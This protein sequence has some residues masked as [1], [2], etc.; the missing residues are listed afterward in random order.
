MI[1]IALNPGFALV[2]GAGLALA[3]PQAI[4]TTLMALSGIAACALILAPPF[5]D[6]DRFAQIGLQLVPL[7]L[8]ALSQIFGLSFAIGAI[9]ISF[10]ASYRRRRMEDVAIML[11]AGGATSAAFAGDLISFVAASEVS[12]LAG[13]WIVFSAGGRAALESGVRLLI[14]QGL[15]GLLLFSGIALHLADGFNSAFTRLPADSVGGALC[16]AGLGIKAAAPFAH[17]WFREA[18][19]TSS[20]TGAAALSL[21]SAKLALY[22]LARGFTGESILSPAGAA[23]AVMGALMALADEDLRRAL[24]FSL[25]G[26]IGLVIAA[27][28]V[29]APLALA[30]AAGHV[31]TTSIAY[32]LLVLAAGVVCERAGTTRMSELP[33]VIA[34]MPFTAILVLLGGL[35]AAAIPGFAG[36]IS[37]SLALEAIARSGRFWS[38]VAIAAASAGVVAFAA[39]RLPALFLGGRGATQAG[40]PFGVLLA[41]ALGAFL[42]IAIGLAPGW[43]LEI[44]PPAPVAYDAYAIDR[45]GERL[46][47][48][49]AAAAGFAGLLWLGLTHGR[50]ERWLNDVDAFYRGPLAAAARELGRFSQQVYG[51]VSRANDAL[52]GRGARGLLGLTRLADAPASATRA[53]PVVGALIMLGALILMYAMVR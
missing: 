24:A 11:M 47:F 6:Y 15:G 20:P 43:L 22:G 38:W 40:A 50:R 45:L 23:M 10:A 2:I 18:L 29:G 33:R 46:E 49:A 17:V 52:M 4:R 5:G 32:V 21:F 39:V 25:I 28:G 9:L 44:L 35:S 53:G 42:C 19:S 14:W 48:K 1:P 37:E 34:P 41:M 36:Y 26:Q 7:R 30:G 51:G 3:A 8:D 27:I 31:F 16:L 12:A 13:A